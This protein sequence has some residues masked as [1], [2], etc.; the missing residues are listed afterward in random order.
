ML[1]IVVVGMGYAEFGQMQAAGSA[2]RGRLQHILRRQR[3]CGFVSKRER[4]PQE[5]EDVGFGFHVRG[6]VAIL[7]RRGHRIASEW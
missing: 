4:V 3:C 7:N 1:S 2:A 5:L 6:T